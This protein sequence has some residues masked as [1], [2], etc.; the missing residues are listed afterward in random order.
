MNMLRHIS[1]ACIAVCMAA[2]P[3][4]MAA[5]AT[6]RTIS[7]VETISVNTP[8]G[9]VPRLP[10]QLLVTYSDGTQAYRQIRWS[11]AALATE[12]EQASY[13]VGKTYTV[14]GYITG[15]DTTPNGFP[16]TAEVS[17]SEEAYTVPSS[18][19]IAEPLPLNKVHL[20]G[21]NRLTSNRDLAIR[22]ILSWD[23]SQ[24]LYN[25]RDTY[26]LSTEG[27]TVSNGWDSP[28]TKLKGHGSGHYM[29]A[30][31]F[32]FA[33]ASDESQKDA[34]RDRIRRMVDELRLCQERTF[35]WNDS[36][37][38]YWEARDF[39]P[40]AELRDMLGTWEAFNEHKTKWE[41]YGSGYR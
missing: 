13:P 21:N 37:G 6:E 36:L 41:S 35:V 27:Y 18:T 12:Q 20:T 8:V 15:D 22:E 24:Q 33:S 5:Q 25:Y 7:S 34:L 32:A 11:N 28:T 14:E 16:I 2:I 3:F 31:A 26:G 40:E 10:Y 17:V 9:T 1:A 30:L 29:S 39:A 23:V 19:P 4:Q 38:R